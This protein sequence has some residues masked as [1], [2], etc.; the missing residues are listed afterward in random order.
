M[1]T[2][3]ISIAEEYLAVLNYLP[4][5]ER[6]YSFGAKLLCKI[7]DVDLKDY[8]AEKIAA[9]R[10]LS[11]QETNPNVQLA[12]SL[13]SYYE[14]ECLYHAKQTAYPRSVD[15]SDT[16]KLILLLARSD[17]WQTALKDYEIKH[18]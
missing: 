14:I 12:L 3:Q 9:K 18:K 8:A 2:R 7:M 4:K 6:K 5:E 1:R 13:E 10:L 17:D 11:L 16:C 15:E